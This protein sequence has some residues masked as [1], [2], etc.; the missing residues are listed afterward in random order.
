MVR[1]ILK[2]T[3]IIIAAV[4]ALSVLYYLIT[5]GLYKENTDNKKLDIVNINTDLPEENVAYYLADWNLYGKD[6]DCLED[7]IKCISEIEAD[8]VIVRN[9]NK[10][11]NE[12]EML[13][14]SF[15]E[16]NKSFLN[17]SLKLPLFEANISQNCLFT[18]SKFMVTG[19]SRSLGLCS[20]G[21]ALLLSPC[22]Y[23]QK[24]VFMTNSGKLLC[25][26]NLQFEN[27]AFTEAYTDRT[28]RQIAVI[29]GD[30]IKESENGNYIIILGLFENEILSSCIDENLKVMNS[31]NNYFAVTDNIRLLSETEQI[32]DASL[33]CFS[34]K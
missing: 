3:L 6:N 13:V 18:F 26:Y 12:A 19:A 1:R 27:R 31:G 22:D 20:A 29:L 23:C 21:D 2:I 32:G 16:Y 17:G 33:L 9:A 11:E 7:T 10:I 34:L 14:D 8:F 5:V 30:A 24:S 25:I 28:N 15:E 4:F